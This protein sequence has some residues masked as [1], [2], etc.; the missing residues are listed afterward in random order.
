MLRFNVG[1]STFLT[2][3]TSFQY[4]LCYGSTI[5]ILFFHVLN[6]KFQYILCYGSTFFSN[7]LLVL[8]LLFQYILCYGSTIGDDTSA[9]KT[10]VFQY[11]LCYGSTEFTFTRRADKIYFNTSYVTVQQDF[12]AIFHLSM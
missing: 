1:S 3:L 9:I 5:I 6:F 11:I 2:S 4:I 12:F 10:F 8:S 7:G